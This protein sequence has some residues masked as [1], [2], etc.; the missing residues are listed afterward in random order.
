MENSGKSSEKV[1]LD[2]VE[3]IRL[4][5]QLVNVEVNKIISEAQELRRSWDDEQY[6]QF[7]KFINSLSSSLI[8][9]TKELDMS[10]NILEERVRELKKWVNIQLI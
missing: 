10:A 1:V 3:G 9:D 4:F 7:I 2:L 8:T 5:S 6:E